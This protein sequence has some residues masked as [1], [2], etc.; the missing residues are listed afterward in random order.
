MEKFKRLHAIAAPLLVANIDTGALAPSQW[1]RDNPNNLGPGLLLEM[2]QDMN[3]VEYPDFV[4]NQHRYKNCEILLAGLNFGCGSSRE[5]AVWALMQ[6]GIKC[7]IAPG[8]GEIFRDN[9]YQNGLLPVELPEESVLRLASIVENAAEPLLS[10]DLEQG[11]VEASGLALRFEVPADRKAALLEGLDETMWLRRCENDIAGF[12]N[13][14]K[15]L[16]P[17]IYDRTVTP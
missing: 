12:R 17:W 10:V 13:H 15:I 9:A 6:F 1:G 5:T 11:I 3:G 4:L 2:R 16:R 14:D 8:Y 7:V